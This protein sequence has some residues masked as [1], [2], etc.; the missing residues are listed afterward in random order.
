VQ[1]LAAVDPLAPVKRLAF[2]DE[3]QRQVGQ[4][5]QISACAHRSLL[6]D[7]R[8]DTRIDQGHEQIHELWPAPA[9]TLGQHIGAQQQ[10]GARLTL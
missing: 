2:A 6:R 8:M 7:Y 4:G 10:H 1:R 5:R 9:E 3:H